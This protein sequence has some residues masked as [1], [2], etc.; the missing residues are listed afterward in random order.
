MPIKYSKQQVAAKFIKYLEEA[1]NP[2][3]FY[4]E[5]FFNQKS[6]TFE[7]TPYTEVYSELILDNSVVDKLND[8]ECVCRRNSYN[9]PGHILPTVNKETNQTEKT[10][11]KGLLNNSFDGFGR[12]IGFEIPLQDTSKDVGGDI[13][14]LSY[15]EQTNNAFILELKEPKSP[16]TLLRCAI[17]AYTYYKRVNHAK[18]ISDFGLPGDCVLVPAPLVFTGSQAA[19]EYLDIVNRPFL[20]SLLL[21]LNAQVFIIDVDD[22]PPAYR[23]ILK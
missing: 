23:S 9:P 14:L 2:E 18:L 15:N 3:T 20:H 13:D 8:I 16:E 7:G 10:I 21:K 5:S 11:A 4:R 6:L 12:V 19:N 1:F 22:I 17:E